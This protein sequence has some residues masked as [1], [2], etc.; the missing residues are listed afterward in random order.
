MDDDDALPRRTPEEQ[1]VASSGLLALVDALDAIDEVHGLMVV[2]RGAVVAEG[3]W[4]PYTADRPHQLFSLSKTFTAVAVGLAEAEG[5]L[6]VD[7]LLL[8]HLPLGD[9]AAPSP[10]LARMRLEHLLTMTTGHDEDSTDR[11]FAEHDWVQAFLRLPVEHE[12]GSHFVYDTAA[13]AMLSAVVQRVT[14]ERVLDVLGPRV[15]AP[16]GIRGMTSEQSPTGFD[17]GGTGMSA[18]TEDVARL[19][20]LLLGDGV[21]RGR[22]LLPEGWVGRATAART[23]SAGENPDWTE[24]Y[25]Y[26][27]W[28]GRHG[29]VRGDGAFGQFCVVLPEQ[30]TVVAVTGGTRDMQAVLDAL[31]AHL[32]PAVSGEASAPDPAAHARLTERLA[33]LRHEPPLGRPPHAGPWGGDTAVVVDPNPLGVTG[34]RVVAGDRHTFLTLTLDGTADGTAPRTTA[35]DATLAGGHGRWQLGQVP[36]HWDLPGRP[37]RGAERPEPVA[38]AVSVDDHG[39]LRLTVRLLETPFVADVRLARDGEDVTVTGQVNVAFGATTIA[40]VRGWVRSGAPEAGG[41]PGRA[42]VP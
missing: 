15:L 8:D 30:A 28:R 42:D 12:P 24:G 39:A 29:S 13:T 23:P 20:M 22:R 7:D 32:L 9:G 11:V 21:W 37:A 10:H 36:G 3:W 35:G 1:G 41:A 26:Q 34:L 31:W 6:C 18:R 4:D 5:R 19:G 40:P 27:M 38:C 17:M 33:G 2:T 16:L 14:G 25:G